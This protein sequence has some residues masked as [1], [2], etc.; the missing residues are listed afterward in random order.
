MLRFYQTSLDRHAAS[1]PAQSH[2]NSEELL[3][4][5]NAARL[6][7]VLS[8]AAILL[9]AGQS[10]SQ[11]ASQ[12]PNSQPNP[13]HAVENWAQLGRPWGSTSAVDVD[14]GGHIWAAERCG[15]NSCAASDLDPVLE[16]DRSGKLLRSFG[17]GLFVQP[18]GIAADRDGN[19][20]ITDA[21]RA[22][23]K[24]DQVFKFSPGRQGSTRSR[25]GRRGRQRPRHLQS[26]N[27]C[28][29]RA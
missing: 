2:R 24:G 10:F 28:G 5:R 23:N 16:F 13:Y 11:T 1:E 18:H 8:A 19:I 12:L 14:R 22:G 20:W 21:Q 9:C 4:Q 26:A 17:K 6:A 27:R 15:A 3:S 25:Q 7:G 29:D